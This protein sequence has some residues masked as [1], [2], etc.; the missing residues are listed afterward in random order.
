[1]DSRRW[2]GIFTTSILVVLCLSSFLFA[3][4]AND[5]SQKWRIGIYQV[6]SPGVQPETIAWIP[7]MFTEW[8]TVKTDLHEADLAYIEHQQALQALKSAQT[9]IH[10]VWLGED[11][12][13]IKDVINENVVVQKTDDEK[14]AVVELP[15][16][17]VMLQGAS[18]L[19]ALFTH[20]NPEFMELL[21]EREQLMG[22]FVIWPSIMED[23]LRLRVVYQDLVGGSFEIL[24]DRIVQPKDVQELQEDLLLSILPLSYGDGMTLIYFEHAVPDL[25]VSVNGSEC[26][27]LDDHIVIP[28]G[29][30]SITLSAFGHES[31]QIDLVA[32]PGVRMLVDGALEES[33][34]G[35]LSI[36]SALG[37]VD[38]FL[39]GI[40]QES[41]PSLIPDQKLPLSIVAT[42]EGFMASPIQSMS[43]IR[44]IVFDLKPEWMT[45]ENL[46]SRNQN[47]FYQSMGRLLGMF[48][49]YVGLQSFASTFSDNGG[50]R[51]PLWQ[52]WI[53]LSGGAAVVSVVDLIGSLFAY[54]TGTRYSTPQQG[55]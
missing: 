5:S 23:L 54:Y 13:K 1:M 20:A 2:K 15:I 51:D 19:D 48:G 31:K 28:S 6:T 46:I 45:D 16:E 7:Q 30:V 47:F 26:P 3:A 37:K 38:W 22:V 9:D 10:T 18:I 33:S 49:L 36:S 35:P 11:Q 21:G 44:N 53:F 34:F 55:K 8:F 50:V 24:F 52:P 40:R 27:L 39:D 4:N 29:A 32:E 17:Y 42:R 12:D 14:N 41:L 25:S 43:P